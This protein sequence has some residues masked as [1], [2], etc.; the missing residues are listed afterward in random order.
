PQFNLFVVGIPL[1][2]AIGLIV[3]IITIPIFVELL[4]VLFSD[5]NREVTDVIK[6]MA[7]G[8]GI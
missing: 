3:M 4:D 6:K 7:E 2:I 8:I 1:K 5:M